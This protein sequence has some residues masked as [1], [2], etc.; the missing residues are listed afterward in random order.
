MN[1]FDFG[2][3]V[4]SE[5]DSLGQ[6][7]WLLIRVFA[8]AFSAMT[9]GA[10]FWR[11]VG[12]AFAFI[13]GQW[14]P[15]V[16][17]IAGMIA[18]DG[19]SQAWAYVRGHQ[20]ST[21]RQMSVARFMSWADLLASVV[22][23]VVYLL[24]NAA[25]D[26]GIYAADGTLSQLGFVLNVIGVIILV[27]AIAGN[28]VAAHLFSD[29]SASNREA[30]HLTEMGAMAATARHRIAKKQALLTAESTMGEI[31]SI[32]P[33]HTRQRAAD[34][35][36]RFINTQYGNEQAPPTPLEQQP[37]STAASAGNS[38]LSNGTPYLV[39][40]LNREQRTWH[41]R[42]SH[43]DFDTAQWRVDTWTR[44]TAGRDVYRVLFNGAVIYHS[45]NVTDVPP[46]AQEEASPITAEDRRQ[47]AEQQRRYA[48]SNE[49]KAAAME[50]EEKEQAHSPLPPLSTPPAANGGNHVN[51][52]RATDPN[53]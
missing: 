18:L 13:F 7:L 12:D 19:L 21:T 52:K 28:F 10:F 8:L 22:V 4:D 37:T 43:P 25:F 2:F 3:E 5:N 39:Q 1:D 24:L 51:G 16:T 20:S 34:N 33:E 6:L 15:Y 50:Q 9:T 44:G 53:G 40:Q 45:D 49:R 35:R 38:P 42:E 30:V 32:L 17:A 41:A 11:Y 31:M 27:A 14:S 48:E 26:V 47:W 46:R 23:T 36:D 29:A